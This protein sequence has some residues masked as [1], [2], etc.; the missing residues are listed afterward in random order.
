MPVLHDDAMHDAVLVE[1]QGLNALCTQGAIP[2]NWQVTWRSSINGTS[3]SKQSLLHKWPHPSLRQ[4]CGRVGMHYPAM[5]AQ[6]LI[7]KL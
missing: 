6:P 3:K 1:L 4:L 5:T 2:I 7:K